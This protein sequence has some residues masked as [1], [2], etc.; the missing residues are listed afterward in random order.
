MEGIVTLLH[1]S[2]QYSLQSVTNVQYIRS[3]VTIARL[4]IKE[5]YF[6]LQGVVTEV[7][8][9]RLALKLRQPSPSAEHRSI[10]PCNIGGSDEG[11]SWL[12]QVP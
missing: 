11:L 12:K 7:H 1:K 2:S 3:E 8:V 9:F 4:G 5:S 10:L 6:C